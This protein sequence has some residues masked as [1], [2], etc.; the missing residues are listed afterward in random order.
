[1]REMPKEESK[2]IYIEPVV[3]DRT[4]KKDDEIN[5][6]P[7]ILDKSERKKF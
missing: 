1:M 3:L 7:V 6:E 2:E 5:I 4:K